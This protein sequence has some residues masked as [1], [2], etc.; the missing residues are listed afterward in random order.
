M[1]RSSRIGLIVQKGEGEKAAQ[2]GRTLLTATGIQGKYVGEAI[3]GV[4]RDGSVADSQVRRLP[5]LEQAEENPEMR[6]LVRRFLHRVE[7][8]PALQEVGGMEARAQALFPEAATT[9]GYVGSKACASCHE[10]EHK[11]WSATR[12]AK[13]YDTL[14]QRNRQ[15][16]PA[17]HPA[18]PWDSAK[19]AAPRKARPDPTCAA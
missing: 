16:L 5:V 11:Q 17:C 13:A 7:K 15:F 19:P 9:G 14:L 1:A 8:N 2:V 6:K 10:A 3:L 4:T 18:T 12:H